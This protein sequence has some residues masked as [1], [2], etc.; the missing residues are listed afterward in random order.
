MLVITWKCCLFITYISEH[1]VIECLLS[2]LCQS[3]VN[4]RQTFCFFFF[5]C[6]FGFVYVDDY[7]E[8]HNPSEMRDGSRCL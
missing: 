1:K 5:I 4:K 3:K 8:D 7:S 2:C 6:L